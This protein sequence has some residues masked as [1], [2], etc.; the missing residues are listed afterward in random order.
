MLNWLT[1]ISI[2][3]TFIF[4]LKFLQTIT[5]LTAS[6]VNL[7]PHLCETFLLCK[8]VPLELSLEN[9]LNSMK[10]APLIYCMLQRQELQNLELKS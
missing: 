10:H 8:K 3:R 4:H 5:K 7:L 1:G 9:L 6:P 2:S